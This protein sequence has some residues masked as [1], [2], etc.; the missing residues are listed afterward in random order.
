[1]SEGAHNSNGKIWIFSNQGYEV[2]VE[3][4]SEQQLTVLL[5]NQPLSLSFYV[6]IVY[7]KCDS[8]QRLELW[9]ELFSIANR[10]DKPWI[11]GGDFNVV[12]NSE[13]KIGGLPVRDAD[14]EDF[15]TCI[16]SCDLAQVK[17]KGSPFTWWN[18]RDG[19]D[20]IFERLDRILTNLKFQNSFSHSEVDHLPR[21]GSDHAPMLLTCD[22]RCIIHR[23]PFK[24]LNFWTEHESFKEVIRLNWDTSISENTFLYFKR[25]IRK[26][27]RAFGNYV[28]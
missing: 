20:C 1:M 6:T 27:K 5:Q 22:D 17:F 28:E 25:K 23:K 7:A 15:K 14:C 13:E 26:I 18:G 8:I 9:D 2:T 16:E 24:F 10:M 12:L 19:N 3:S 21:T 11:I 4:S